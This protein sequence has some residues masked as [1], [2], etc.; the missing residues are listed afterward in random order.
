MVEE[1]DTREVRISKSLTQVL[2][3]KALLLGLDVRADGYVL[4]EMVLRCQSVARHGATM[5]DLQKIV[6]ESNK[7][8]FQ[9][10][11]GLDGQGGPIYIRAVQGHSMTVVQDEMLG[12]R[13]RAND[14]DLPSE[15]VC[16]GLT[17]GI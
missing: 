1:E 15:C 11:Q 7:Q 5:A 4:A 10:K 16:T 9:L 6:L 3:H 14:Q 2:R 13:L 12:R 17:S 8:R